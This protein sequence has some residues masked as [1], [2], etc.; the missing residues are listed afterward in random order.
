MCILNLC[1]VYKFQ[2]V[3]P[4]CSLSQSHTW[5]NAIRQD[6]RAAL[7]FCSCGLCWR[8]AECVL[9]LLCFN[10]LLDIFA[11]VNCADVALSVFYYSSVLTRCWIFLQLSTALSLDAGDNLCSLQWHIVAYNNE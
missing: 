9:L 10:A 5:S 6:I 1:V 11:V 3:N 4:G 2:T 7:Y 8:C